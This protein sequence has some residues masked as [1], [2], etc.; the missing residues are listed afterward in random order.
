MASFSTQVSATMPD[1]YQDS[2]AETL[3]DN[4][5]GGF[6]VD[7]WECKG[8]RDGDEDREDPSAESTGPID[9]GTILSTVSKVM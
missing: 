7:E 2:V 1:N 9:T 6:L 5:L 4:N 8:D 3:D